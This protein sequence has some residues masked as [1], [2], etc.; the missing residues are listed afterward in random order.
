MLILRNIQ[1]RAIYADDTTLISTSKDV[2]ATV[3]SQVDS[4]ARE[5]GLLLKPNV[6]LSYMMVPSFYL[7]V[8]PSL[9]VQL[10]PLQ[11]VLQSFWAS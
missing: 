11:K 7:T 9:E 2:H 6:S 1:L 8:S 3:L 5:I 10:S 4:K